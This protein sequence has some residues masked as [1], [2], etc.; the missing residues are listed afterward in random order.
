MEG[1]VPVDQGR[2][3]DEESSDVSRSSSQARNRPGP[4]A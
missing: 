2:P 1:W 4:A 3:L